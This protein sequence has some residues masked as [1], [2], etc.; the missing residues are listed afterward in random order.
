[1]NNLRNK[2]QL[3]GHIGKAPEIL[4]FENGNKMA[5]FS[6][7]TNENYKNAKGEK[8]EG[9]FFVEM[10]ES[11]LLGRKTPIVIEVISNGKKVDEVKTNFMGIDGP[12]PK[13]E[14]EHEDEKSGEE[15]EDDSNKKEN[16]H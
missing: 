8:V 4:T 12:L 16:N 3:I 10:P 15:H 5:K 13:M 6:L 1:M 9:A 2:V 11:E 7:A 14:K